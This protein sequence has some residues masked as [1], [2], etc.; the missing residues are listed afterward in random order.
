[1]TQL[2]QSF[3][4]QHAEFFAH[5]VR[6]GKRLVHSLWVEPMST[7]PEPATEGSAGYPPM[8]IILR[9]GW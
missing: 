8:A 5:L 1:L 9:F 2:L 7:G 6:I 3:E 4:T